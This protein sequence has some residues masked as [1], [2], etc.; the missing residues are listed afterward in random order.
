M[1]TKKLSA[2]I[3]SALLVLGSVL[4]GAL[5][6]NNLTESKASNI[7][8]IGDNGV[9]VYVSGEGVTY[10]D[11]TKKYNVKDGETVTIT[12]VND[13]RMFTS[14]TIGD[15]TY[16]S[17]VV[18]TTVNGDLEISLETT[19]STSDHQGKCFGR[20][21]AIDEEG[22]LTKLVNI[23][24]GKDVHYS[25][26]PGAESLEDIQYGYYYVD[27]S[28]FYDT[29]NFYG[30]GTATNPFHGCI[31]F[32]NNYI[33]VNSISEGA[34]T[35][36]YAG[37][38]GV[39]ENG[40]GREIDFGLD[41][42][43]NPIK[44]VQKECVIR[45]VTLKG[46]I[47]FLDKTDESVISELSIGGV[48]GLIGGDVILDNVD[49]S[50]SINVEAKNTSIT[51]GVLFGTLETRIDSWEE[52]CASG[53]Y[54]S[55]K[56]IT[57]GNNKY[58]Y[59]GSLAG[60]VNNS[61]IYKYTNNISN[62]IYIANSLHN[63]S[64]SSVA[65]SVVGV[66]NATSKNVVLENITF[67]DYENIDISSVI[68]NFT[69]A[70][71]NV[72]G[73]FVLGLIT[74]SYRV[75]INS[76]DFVYQDGKQE[77]AK[78]YVSS[79]RCSTASTNS[80]GNIY[81]GG[82]IGYSSNSSVYL[83]NLE[84][85]IFYKTNVYIEAEANGV[86]SAFAGGMFGYTPAIVDNSVQKDIV[87]NIDGTS[88]EVYATQLTGCSSSND[89]TNNI[90]AAAGYYAPLLNISDSSR[91]LNKLELTVNKGILESSRQVGSTAVGNIYAGGLIG[92]V[93][94]QSS[95]SNQLQD[96]T[97]NLNDSSVSGLSLSF[98]SDGVNGEEKWKNNVDVGGMFGHLANC[99]S[100][101]SYT[102]STS[103]ISGNI[104]ADNLTVNILVGNNNK[105]YAVKGIQNA[106]AG[107][108]DHQNQGHIG[109]AIGMLKGGYVGN[110]SVIGDTK[111]IVKPIVT[112]I[113]TNSPNTAAA[114][115]V[116]G[117]N[118]RDAN[119][120]IKDAKVSN[121][122]VIAKAFCVYEQADD[123]YDVYSGG[124]I[125]VLANS[126][127]SYKT[128]I[129]D[130]E[131]I[132][133]K[134][135]CIGEEYMLTY[136]GGTAGGLWWDGDSNIY[137]AVVE[138][139]DIMASSI[140]YDSF[141]GG[142]AGLV[143]RT[144]HIEN[145][146][147]INNYISAT[148]K[149]KNAFSGGIAARIRQEGP[150][151]NNCYVNST[152]F[153]EGIEGNTITNKSA[154]TFSHGENANVTF[155]NVFINP[156]NLSVAEKTEAGK[157]PEYWT[158][159]GD[160]ANTNP[161]IYPLYIGNSS[162]VTYSIE[163][164]N[165]ESYS[166][167]GYGALPQNYILRFSGDTSLLVDSSSAAISSDKAYTSNFVKVNSDSEGVVYVS[168]RVT[169]NDKEYELVNQPIYINKKDNVAPDS[170]SLNN[171]DTKVTITN[172]NNEVAG[173]SSGKLDDYNTEY[174]YAVVNVG[175]TEIGT[176]KKATQK[177]QISYSDFKNYN[178]YTTSAT[179]EEF[180]DDENH[181]IVPNDADYD[182]RVASIL[183][184][185]QAKK[186]FNFFEYLIFSY[187]GSSVILT[188]RGDITER[189]VII[190]EFGS[191]TKLKTVIVEFVPNLLERA[192]IVPASYTDELGLSYD[193][194]GNKIYTY[195]PGDVINFEVIEHHRFAYNYSSKGYT[196]SGALDADDKFIGYK[197]DGTEVELSTSSGTDPADVTIDSNGRTV[198][199]KTSKILGVK[200]GV[201]ATSATDSSVT[202]IAYIFVD[203]EVSFTYS[204]KGAYF[205][206]NRKVV[207]GTDFDF[208]VIPMAGYG[209]V[210]VKLYVSIKKDTS[211]VF[212]IKDLHYSLT[213][214]LKNQ[215]LVIEYNDVEYTFIYSFNLID[216]SYD[217]TI[218]GELFTVDVT[219]LN[220][221]VEFG[222][223]YNVVFDKGYEPANGSGRY[224]I[225]Q[226][227]HG[228]TL[229]AELFN[230]IQALIQA[231]Q[232][233]Y[234][235]QGY[236]LVQDGTSLDDYG[237]SF[238]EYCLDPNVTKTVT[239]PMQFYARYT[240]E[241][242]ALLPDIFGI[243]T[244]L[245]LDEVMPIESGNNELISI[246]PVDVNNGFTFVLK[247]DG[248]WYG[249]I[250][251]DVFVVTKASGINIG[252]TTV[253]DEVLKRAGVTKVTNEIQTI[254]KNTYYLPANL[255]NGYIVIRGYAEEMTFSAG[256][257][258]VDSG[259]HNIYGDSVFTAMYAVTYNK[260]DP[261]DI[262]ETVSYSNAEIVEGNEVVKGVEFKFQIENNSHV[263]EEFYLPVGTSIRLYRF[264]NHE[265]YDVGVL[266]LDEE[267][268]MIYAHDFKDI[269]TG[270]LLTLPNVTKVYDQKYNLVITLPNHK[271][272]NQD[273]SNVEIDL[274]STF[275]EHYNFI[276]YINET[277]THIS[278]ASYESHAIDYFNIY[279]TIGFSVDSQNNSIKFT[280]GSEVAGV[281]D[282]R[283]ENKYFVW[284][285]AKTT[286]AMVGSVDFG[287]LTPI[288][289]TND[290]YY[291]LATS[292]EQI[293]IN[294]N[295]LKGYTISI[296][297]VDNI[298]DPA[299]GILVWKEA[300][301]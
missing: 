59:V 171:Y 158:T 33:S 231:E 38:F 47:S 61:S 238:E 130:S 173:Y 135:E 120:L 259:V 112:F 116:I 299:S 251:F 104:G 208:T 7:S 277:V 188:P 14:M 97:I 228:T 204:V 5:S 174:Y 222:S 224:F 13:Q 108:H 279:K 79:I 266:I 42:D 246:I 16:N 209:L 94:C 284:K 68:D 117:E 181:Y 64:G 50:V 72:Y 25:Y 71:E 83:N 41:L 39:I 80:K 145:C 291:Y 89:S 52:V 4:F 98:L 127:G 211:I 2:I 121:L 141:A 198:I 95:Y 111:S 62:G 255:I 192:E 109:G 21:W 60:K 297:E 186:D 260:S 63:D 184:S 78:R 229:D 263:K 233:G 232:Y 74:G 248:S 278:N 195:A 203:S 167:F 288:V 3:S 163:L 151:F 31:D 129:V 295:K 236:Y 133:S 146:Y 282:Y 76:I 298:Q 244:N 256:E 194:E 249:D 250:P 293:S 169:Y 219:E 81:A 287:G 270:N 28:I 103:A 234:E 275:T 24:N 10:N 268:S 91:Y 240:Y 58:A 205:E 161:N 77:L 269:N 247:H 57:S 156:E 90:G 257:S 136:A 105:D 289:K 170:I 125:G 191:G 281:T 126:G 128:Y 106:V 210:P 264:I 138:N 101:T 140:S 162:A 134:I 113:S 35:S 139:S 196:F 187:D 262:K 53:A 147:I 197:A 166:L 172:S 216:G 272:Y 164:N 123:K 36:S 274:V 252:S 148:S 11:S 70:S 220:I 292:G 122:H 199:G 12:V 235:F 175:Q 43:D 15:N 142:I 273:Y 159:W 267:K 226:L 75:D 157:Y 150:A 84:S 290:A 176:N 245:Y 115:G 200:F 177:I 202:T 110:V 243:D 18:S 160:G 276:D 183:D 258:E 242:V 213:N 300:I 26:F 48:A 8:I 182:T 239:G 154:F 254:G 149:E 1:K 30:I 189:V 294:K 285:V 118:N 265:L 66:L 99:G 65:S 45:N 280:R 92:A 49:S 152:I 34:I 207:D 100:F 168:L 46:N 17:S 87:L 86:G 96:L 54:T 237:Y 230:E 185:K 179:L 73:S 82:L 9:E 165:T 114:G 218:P 40:S 93:Y 193:G 20:A 102:A 32:V 225:Y 301:S 201:Q 212:D 178:L 217:I 56:A 6:L 221:E 271:G 27:N 155:S 22:D 131:V 283:H 19:Y 55:V 223:T 143:Q 37:F 119:A 51:A 85:K 253:T 44:T 215:E 227:T 67:V 124:I 180:G 261:V 132:N 107:N 23:L 153:A 88:I 69:G 241:V 296:L 144:D 206:S 214:D 190:Y 137:N 29:T 286:P